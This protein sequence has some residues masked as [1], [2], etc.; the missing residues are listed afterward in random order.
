[1]AYAAQ[2]RKNCFQFE[3][4]EELT[5]DESG[6]AHEDTRSHGYSEIEI[7]HNTVIR[8]LINKIEFGL[9]IYT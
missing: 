4:K 5:N 1:M 9:D 7:M 2:F 6:F 3:K 8:I